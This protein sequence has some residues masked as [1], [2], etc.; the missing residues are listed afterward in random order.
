MLTLTPEETLKY[1][2]IMRKARSK[3]GIF[4]RSKTDIAMHRALQFLVGGGHPYN[5]SAG[6]SLITIMSNGDLYP[7]RRMP[8]KVGNVMETPLE[9]LYYQ[10]PLF[11]ALRNEENISHNCNECSH[12]L[13][14]RG[15]LKCLS[16]ATSGNPFE[17]DPG[18][19]IDPQ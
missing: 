18:C 11:V 19:Y 8:I 5:C 4:Q 17:R 13:L 1:F 3:R 9:T 14:C 6:D 16:Y 15:G 7:C 2:N 10:S 12:K